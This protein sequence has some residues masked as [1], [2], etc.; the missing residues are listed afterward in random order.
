M[1]HRMKGQFLT[2]RPR[3]A[4]IATVVHIAEPPGRTDAGRAIKSES[5]PHHETLVSFHQLAMDTP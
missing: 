4:A 2:I 5:R 1:R 3:Q